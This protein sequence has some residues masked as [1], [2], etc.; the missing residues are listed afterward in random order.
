MARPSVR[1][2]YHECHACH[3]RIIWPVDSNSTPLPPLNWASASD[4]FGTVAV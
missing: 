1:T 3:E 2:D 4:P